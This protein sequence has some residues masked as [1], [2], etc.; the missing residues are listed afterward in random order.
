MKMFL[1]RPEILA[2]SWFHCLM[3]LLGRW[4]IN[5]TKCECF[6]K[7][8]KLTVHLEH[9]RSLLNSLNEE[10][11]NF[12]PVYFASLIENSKSSPRMFFNIV[13]SVIERPWG[14]IFDASPE[15]CNKFLS[16]FSQKVSAIRCCISPLILQFQL[17]SLVQFPSV[18][19]IRFLH[20]YYLIW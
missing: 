9:P 16:L 8:A 12:R 14:Q 6:W 7:S 18:H 13:G 5:A 10:V 3:K 19:T 11:E 2:A 17:R 4:N 15:K 1:S 20:L